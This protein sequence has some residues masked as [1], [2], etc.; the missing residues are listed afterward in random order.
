MELPLKLPRIGKL[1][2]RQ[3]ELKFGI[4]LLNIYSRTGWG[5]AWC[6]S[7]EYF[8]CLLDSRFT[9]RWLWNFHPLGYDVVWSCQSQPTFRGTSPPSSGSKS[10]PNRKLAW[11]REQTEKDLGGFLLGA[12]FDPKDGSD[13]LSADA[14]A[15]GIE[16]AVPIG[17]G[18]GCLQSWSARCG[19]FPYPCRESNPD[20]PSN[21]DL[22]SLNGS[23]TFS[24]SPLSR[25]RNWAFRSSYEGNKY[26]L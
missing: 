4:Y 16:I 22:F 25:M 26:I 2:R 6:H 3:Q 20:R 21:T 8:Y 24:R 19:K 9:Q 13:V 23:E 10:M 14:L 18:L 1:L 11:R 5:K 17:Y 12:L 7:T 15:P